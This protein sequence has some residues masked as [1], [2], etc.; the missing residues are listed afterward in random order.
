VELARFH[1]FYSLKN[2]LRSREGF[3][4]GFEYPRNLQT[5]GVKWIFR[6]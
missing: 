5:F 6:G 1:A 3:F 4:P 2:A